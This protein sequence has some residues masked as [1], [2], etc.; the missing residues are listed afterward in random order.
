MDRLF[1]KIEKEDVTK[2]VHILGNVYFCDVDSSNTNYR[3]AEWT[4][5]DIPVEEVQP[6]VDKKEFMDYINEKVAYLE[7][8]TKEE[9][10]EICKTYYNGTTGGRE[11]NLT[12]LSKETPCGEY[13]CEMGI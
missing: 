10:E 7:D 12:E 1:F 3:I 11:L 6:L 13:Y 9:A 2:N 4:G 5:L 8:I